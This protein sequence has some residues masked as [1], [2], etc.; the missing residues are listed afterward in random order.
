MPEFDYLVG[1]HKIRLPEG[2]ALPDYQ[3]RYRRYDYTLGELAGIVSEKYPGSPR[4][5]VG[6]NIGDSWALMNKHVI[7][8][9]LLIEGDPAYTNLLKFNVNRLGHPAQVC[10]AFCGTTSG[11]VS[12]QSIRRTGAGTSSINNAAAP[13]GDAT[14]PILTFHEILDRHPVF[15]SSR[16][17]KLDTDGYD[18]GILEA[19]ASL[20]SQMQATVYYECAPFEQERGLDESLKS[21]QELVKFFK[22]YVVYDNFGHFMCSM[23]GDNLLEK[24]LELMVFLVSNRVDGA[25]VYY[26]DIAAFTPDNKDLFLKLKDLEISRFFRRHS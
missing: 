26:F 1:G 24:Y 12:E 15:K 18:F 21:F 16:L 17:I 2:H 22:Y 20:F 11:T 13:A 23:E 4:I 25:A 5:D 9:T 7:T 8:E 3:S 14:I 6:A 19:Y 10:E